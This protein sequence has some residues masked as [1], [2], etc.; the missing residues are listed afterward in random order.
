MILVKSV[1]AQG[2]TSNINNSLKRKLGIL[3][4]LGLSLLIVALSGISHLL[5]KNPIQSN[6]EKFYSKPI[7]DKFM[8]SLSR[9]SLKNKLGLTTIFKKNDEWFLQG[10]ATLPIKSSFI[11]QLNDQF[12]NMKIRKLHENDPINNN[13]FSLSSP[14][15][16]ISLG[17][18]LN[19]SIDVFMGITSPVDSSTYL[20]VSNQDIIYQVQAMDI[21]WG[22][23]GVTNI[24]ESRVV[25]TDF[26]EVKAIDMFFGK[27]RK[28]YA[29]FYKKDGKWQSS[30]YKYM[31][32]DKFLRK[33]ELLFTI[34]ASLIVD[35]KEEKTT[36]SVNRIL[37]NPK[38]R[39]VL[40][41]VD[42]KLHTYKFSYPVE[43]IP[44]IKIQSKQYFLAKGN[45]S[46]YPLLIEK[47]LL[48]TV[49]LKY[50]QIH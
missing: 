6:I 8:E 39:V 33:M 20:K 4:I 29:T 47:S 21:N 46:S 40:R 9:I 13:N 45:N 19:E 34:K 2:L 50:N 5:E 24:V 43:K 49:R 41:T 22:N 48:E 16:T 32:E 35:N 15:A 42:K 30:K 38:Y 23:I 28:A 27:E 17:S 11:S 12:K 44:G 25:T 18:K 14:A 7:S 3:S 1:M 36:N 31:K 37:S 26:S 10:R